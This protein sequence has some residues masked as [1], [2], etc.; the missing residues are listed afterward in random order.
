MTIAMKFDNRPIGVFDSGLGGLTVAREIKKRFPG[1]QLVYLGDSAR[2]PYGTRSKEVVM[3]FAKED[4]KFLLKHEVKAVVIACNTASAHAADEVRKVCNLPVW[5]VIGPGARGAIRESR[6]KKI[7]VIGTRGTIGSQAYLKALKGCEV[8]EVACPLF[9]PFIEEGEIRGNIIRELAEKYLKPVAKAG[10]DTLIMGCTH[11]PIIE[12]LIGD[13]LGVGVKLV[14]PGRELARE[15]EFVPTDR[16]K[17]EE[18][19]Y[20]VTDL[21]NRYKETAERFMGTNVKMTKVQI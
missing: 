5:D 17:S 12:A 18:D 19:K 6:T 20:F 10:V 1:E 16:D 9:V 8:T 2:V 15:L 21:T 3:Q 4:L 13:V 7:G 11:Y 14:N